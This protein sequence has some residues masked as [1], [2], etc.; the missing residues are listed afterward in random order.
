M[1]RLR[2]ALYRHPVV[3]GLLGLGLVVGG[4]GFYLVL[5]A[6]A[7]TWTVTNCNDSGPGSLRQAVADASSGDTITFAMSPA[8]STVD[9]A[10]PI[11]VST[12]ITI[13]GPGANVLALSG[14]NANPVLEI[15]DCT[16]SISGLMVE[17][18]YASDNDGI[19]GGGIGGGIYNDGTLTLEDDVV[20]QNSASYEG[21]G[22]FDQSGDIT[23][24]DTTVSN[25]TAQF[26]AGV[27]NGGTDATTALMSYSTVSNNGSSVTTG[28]GGGI[29]NDGTLSIAS[30]TVANNVAYNSGGGIYN[31]G[32]TLNISNSTVADNTVPNTTDSGGDLKTIDGD[33]TIGASIVALSNT[34]A[35][36]CNEVGG[37]FTDL[38]YNLDDD[39]SCGFTTSNNDLPDTNPMLDT[40]GLQNNG[41]PTETI[42]LEPGSPAIDAVTTSSLCPSTDQRGA[43]RSAPCDIGA[44]DTDGPSSTTGPYEFFCPNTSAGNLVMNDVTTTAVMSPLTP[45][46]G[47]SF[48]VT[49]YQTWLYLPSGLVN[50]MAGLGATA[51]SG[52]LS[53]Q[54]DTTDASP[55][56]VASGT[57][58]F[59][60]PIPNPVPGSGMQ[61]VIPDPA[62]SLGPLTA[63]TSDPT[64]EEDPSATLNLVP[65]GE[66]IPSITLDC[67]A[68]PNDTLPTGTSSV[69]PSGSPISPVIAFA[70]SGATSQTVSFT[71]DAPTDAT[72]GGSEYDVTASASSGLPVNTYIDPTS[73]SVCSMSDSIVSF[74]TVGTCT[75]DS[76]Q[77]GDTEYGPSPVAQQSFTVGQGSQ[78]ISFFTTPPSDAQVGGPGYEVSAYSSAGE[79]MP[80]SLTIDSSASS[81]CQISYEV[82]FIGVGQCVIDANQ[83]GNANYLPAPQA[84]QSF[85]VGQGS[86]TIAWSNEPT[87][88]AYDGSATLS[89][90]GG[91]SD[92]P[93]VFSVDSSSG[94]GVCSVS[95]TN[96]TTLSYMGVGTCVVDANQAGDTDY[97]AASQV[98]DSFGV[99]QATQSITITSTPPSPVVARGPSY[100]LTADGGGSGNPITFS[101]ATTSVCSVSEASVIFFGLGTCTLAAN[102]DGNADY[103]PA[104]TATQSFTVVNM[105]RF[106]S[107]TS[108]SVAVDQPFSVTVATEGLPVPRLKK[109]EGKLPKGVHFVADGNGNGTLFGEAQSPSEVGQYSLTFK[110]TF[111]KGHRRVVVLQAFTLSV[112]SG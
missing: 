109:T 64:I 75:V 65:N 8:C 43:P 58:S 2:A 36:D 59:N 11:A 9:L 24:S 82:T 27:W 54:L 100:T 71:T 16:V 47:Q 38:G 89:A 18:G 96:G 92:N 106:S 14:G 29:F 46:P 111:G 17:D 42:A 99:G 97:S 33:V 51:I 21:G 19:A 32:G 49:D 12:T 87:S 60:Q 73:S 69:S 39:G 10:S 15:T 94:T 48:Q 91:G 79:N 95:E 104:P 105:D 22:I 35:Q 52:S 70:G 44:F 56:T 50:G 62:T 74:N 101:S 40:T 90:T 80:V 112:T 1:R 108:L 30:S 83:A 72:V 5:P 110:A 66:G 6:S 67:T 78:T 7:A 88:G 85:A 61:L 41:G 53:T 77:L 4:V 13:Q 25:N 20:S 45:S 37:S 84:Q 81:V 107:S 55:S 31:S 76:V 102:Q 26:G 98:Q 34:S 23:I 93:I 57:Q 86:Q 68:Y 28:F 3:V 103:L 63:T